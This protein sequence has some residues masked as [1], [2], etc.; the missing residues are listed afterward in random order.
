MERYGNKQGMEV[1]ISKFYGPILPL[2]LA[3]IGC[4]LP[5]TS[6]SHSHGHDMGTDHN[7][8]HDMDSVVG[9][10][11]TGTILTKS[12]SVARGKMIFDQICSTCHMAGGKGIPDSIPPLA[13]SDFLM[14]N[15]KRSLQIVMYGTFG[16]IQV[17]GLSYDNVM[18]PISGSDDNVAAVLTFVRNS[19][20]GATDS[21][22]ALE[23]MNER[24]GM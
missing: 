22:T 15:K 17:N 21:V 20:N 23:V 10:V 11:P 6:D 14:A 5:F 8:S 24:M 1:M 9:K 19:L 7:H 12:E 3:L 18:P 16:P 4:N 2:A 13:N